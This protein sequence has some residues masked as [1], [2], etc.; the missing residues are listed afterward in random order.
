MLPTRK[1]PVA[2]AQNGV[3]RQGC[4]QVMVKCQG[5]SVIMGHQRNG[6]QGQ[7]VPIPT[8]EFQGPARMRNQATPAKKVNKSKRCRSSKIPPKP[9]IS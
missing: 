7:V 5:R 9:P 1:P 2:N 3:Q 6:G 8:Q 4:E